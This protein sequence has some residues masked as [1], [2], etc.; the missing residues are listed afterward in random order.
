MSTQRREFGELVRKYRV[1]AGLTQS[2]VAQVA[3][4]V[5]GK[6]ASRSSV[7]HLEQGLRVPSP[8][9]LG[10][11]CAAVGMPERL[12]SPFLS[13][14]SGITDIST[15][16]PARLLPQYIAIAGINGAGK[17]TLL[18]QLAPALGYVTLP[19]SGRGRAY[20]ADLAKDPARWAFET[21]TAFLS[22]KAITLRLLLDRGA[23]VMVD[24]S[25]S[26]DVNVFGKY[27]HQQGDLSGRGFELYEALAM[28]FL[29]SVPSPDMVIFCGCKPDVAIE[30]VGQ[31]GRGD[32]LQTTERL[33]KLSTLYDEWLS[34]QGGAP[35]FVLDSMNNDV[36]DPRIIQAVADDVRALCRPL[37]Q[38]QLQ[39]FDDAPLF[40]EEA[41]PTARLLRPLSSHTSLPVVTAAAMP[42]LLAYL[43]APFTAL[44]EARQPSGKSPT[45]LLF[46]E[47]PGHGQI[48]PGPYRRALLR[49]EQALRTFGIETWIPHRDTNEWGKRH[50]T[51]EQVARECTER[52]SSVDLFIGILSTSAG[53][54]YE[55]G[56]ARGLGKPIVLVHCTALSSTFV[57]HG[58]THGSWTDTL[59]LSCET[60]DELPELFASKTF[61]EF[62]ASHF[63][64]DVAAT[65]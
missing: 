44:A 1:E 50:M 51:E 31:R 46:E 23:R 26:E 5:L 6:L 22:E 45:L 49:I 59:C 34:H 52:T 37:M 35:V 30:R 40:T 58:L 11:I 56:L 55:L 48:P 29:A 15:N 27:W 53:S 38:P 7:A 54:H 60:L 16:T 33:T 64:L 62:I 32:P 14:T 43:A 25:L 2:Q 20:L 4:Q 19:E 47:R 12:W 28:H 63:T 10:A 8:R 21:Q 17:S 65:A 24:R 42:R 13:A 36:R 41:R 18:K 9:V 3:Q 61:H 39:M 57:G